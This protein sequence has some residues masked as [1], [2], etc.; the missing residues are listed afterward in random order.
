MI[1]NNDYSRMLVGV[2]SVLAARYNLPDGS[3]KGYTQKE[4]VGLYIA[5]GAG[6]YVEPTYSLGVTEKPWGVVMA[7]Y[8]FPRG[9]L[10][11]VS[12]HITPASA[13]V[14]IAGLSG[15]TE[16]TGIRYD[17]DAIHHPDHLLSGE[18]KDAKITNTGTGEWSAE[19]NGL[20]GGPNGLYA[21]A[22][23]DPTLVDLARHKITI[24]SIDLAPDEELM[25]LLDSGELK[26]SAALV[27]LPHCG[28]YAYNSRPTFRISGTCP[29]DA[30]WIYVFYDNLRYMETCGHCSGAGCDECCGTGVEL[31]SGLYKRYC[32]GYYP[33]MSM[34]GFGPAEAGRFSFC[35][36]GYWYE[37]GRRA[38]DGE[39]QDDAPGQRFVVWTVS[40][41]RGRIVPAADLVLVGEPL[42]PCLNG[43]TP[44]AMADGSTRPLRDLHFG[45]RV[46]SGSGEATGVISV[47]RGRMHH[48]HTLYTFED[49]TVI[50][51]SADHRFFNVD[52]GYWAWLKDWRI[53]DRARRVDGKE[54][55]LVSR[56]RVD[57]P[58]EC[59]GL[60]TE[61]R[62]YWAG[63]LLSGETM[64]N[65][66]LLAEASAEL[67]AEMLGSIEPE[68]IREMMGG[69]RDD[70]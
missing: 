33:W 18:W 7:R 19:V 26:I 32:A 27:E 54:I 11:S 1:R 47:S 13:Q 59:F 63:G 48:Y 30:E 34:L 9:F 28:E 17:L 3:E 10:Y 38:S 53:G 62:D 55:A 68:M 40:K 67:A 60:W 20:V 36:D 15:W 52:L 14:H 45:D 4:G 46:L 37:T 6:G 22:L 57:E 31:G 5:D 58:A 70:L 43:D 12:G 50:D 69:D 23:C 25:E 39:I 64:A 66:R 16:E 29:A 44:I 8:Y 61:S 51:E 2:G 41:T 56:E 42:D 65:Q 24:D 21:F 35:F 49:G